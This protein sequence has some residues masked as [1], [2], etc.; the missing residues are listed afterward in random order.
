M[1]GSV[2]GASGIIGGA[3][4][5]RGGL[6]GFYD[7]TVGELTGAN[8]A[9]RGAQR[10]AQAQ[11]AFARE[12][13]AFAKKQMGKGLED[14]KNLESPQE[15]AALEASLR[16]QQSNLDR[17]TQLFEALDPAILEASSQALK[18]LRG[19]EA[20][21]L[22]PIK[23][24]RQRQRQSLLNTLREQMGP[25]AETSTAGIQ[26][27]NRFDAE[28]NSLVSGQ[29]QATLANLFNM[30][31]SGAINRGA[32]GNS[33]GQLAT[34]GAAFGDVNRS[35]AQIRA[36]TRLNYLNSVLGQGQ[37]VQQTAGS[38]FVGDTLKGQFQNQFVGDRIKAGEEITAQFMGSFGGGMMAASD[39]NVKADVQD[40]NQD[41]EQ[42]MTEVGVH[43]Y[44]YIDEKHGKGRFAGP[45]AQE[46]EETKLGKASV[47]DTDEGKMVDFARLIPVIVSSLSNLNARLKSMEDKLGR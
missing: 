46:L 5:Q 27:L 17:Q 6:G 36:N 24:D 4:K 28:T 40:A 42:F 23:Q 15:L 25:G 21:A 34:I 11:E 10:T 13:L 43:S 22:S 37:N 7:D 33:A 26:A 47:I 30:G 9:A 31:Q 20:S 8:R 1:A 38:R 3:S 44:E 41:V 45:M 12:Q 18:L 14:I 2:A 32:L 39:R 16:S 35:N 29:Q 19:E